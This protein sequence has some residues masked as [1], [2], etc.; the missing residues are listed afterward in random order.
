MDIRK[1]RQ[2]MFPL[3]FD[4]LHEICT[5]RWVADNSSVPIEKIALYKY[6]SSYEK[7]CVSKIPTKYCVVFYI[8]NE[9]LPRYPK[10]REESLADLFGN[11]VDRT[12]SD[13]AAA[14]HTG[15]LASLDKSIYNYLD[16][17]Q[18]I[19]DEYSYRSLMNAGF[20][21]VYLNNAPV[22]FKEDWLFLTGEL[23][24][25]NRNIKLNESHWVLY[26]EAHIEDILLPEPG[27]IQ[28]NGI[29]SEQG[30]PANLFKRV[31][32][33]W[34]IRYEG[35]ESNPIKHVDGLLYISHL[36]KHP[37]TCISCQKL[38]Q[39][40]SGKATI[41]IMSE[42][43]ISGNKLS[44]G[45]GKQSIDTSKARKV[46]SEKYQEFQ[47]KL[48]TVSL[49][50]QE[51]IKEQMAALEPYL[52]AKKRNFADPNDKKAQ[53]NIKKRLETAYQAI[54][55]ANMT[56]MEE[57]LRKY[58]TSDDAYGLRYIGSLTWDIIIE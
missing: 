19:Y 53:V 16:C 5:E 34:Q 26:D 33:F 45:F 27:T 14:E 15:Y 24:K 56:E 23:A 51:C 22:N 36:L 58:I 29:I 41:G 37:G 8:K 17:F 3:N 25:D 50:E 13:K 28:Q 20:S 46:C 6:S 49:E 54:R 43:E 2:S 40:V 7:N 9:L 18:T 4:L 47:D 1:N 30:K 31:S 52:R 42:N 57:H 39:S 32:D 35:K 12:Y 55:K 11:V 44:I 38:H 10:V 21:D 48:S